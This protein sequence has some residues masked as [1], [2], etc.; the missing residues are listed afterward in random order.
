ML[1]CLVATSLAEGWQLDICCLLAY[2]WLGC[3]VPLSVLFISFE[4]QCY[5]SYSNVSLV[6][7]FTILFVSKLSVGR[8]QWIYVLSNLLV[9]F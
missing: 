1:C 2:V 8:Y 9:L 3:F 4:L 5:L 7:T 6:I